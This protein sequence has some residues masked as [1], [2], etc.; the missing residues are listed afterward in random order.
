R[1]PSRSSSAVQKGFG[2][3]LQGCRIERDRS[4][5]SDV[6]R[7]GRVSREGPWV[8]ASNLCFRLVIGMR[9]GAVVIEYW[10]KDS[11]TRSTTSQ[12]TG[13]MWLFLVRDHRRLR[14]SLSGHA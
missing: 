5:D 10:G 11:R 14:R 4:V 13:S 3:I 6:A 1:P 12:W 2:I 7:S 9:G 8:Q